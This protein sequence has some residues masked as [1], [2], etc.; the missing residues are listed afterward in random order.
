M[1]LLL[2]ANLSYTE[3]NKDAL[4]G[5]F[6]GLEHALNALVQGADDFCL[7]DHQA[8]RG[9]NVHGAVGANGG[10]LA[11]QA[12]HGQAQGLA[13]GLWGGVGAVLAEIWALDVEGGAHTGAQ[14]GGARGHVAEF[15]GVRELGR[16]GF[17][18]LF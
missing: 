11:T 15:L 12:A 1:D 3:K 7:L 2:P 13:D 4:F 8:S 16:V 14:V 17:H 5:S 10:V 18:H 9:R 6:F